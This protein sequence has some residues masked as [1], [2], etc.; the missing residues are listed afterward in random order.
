M[1][2]SQKGFVIP[3]I[4]VIVA[5]LV[6]GGGVYFYNIKNKSQKTT[7]NKP[8]VVLAKASVTPANEVGGGGINIPTVNDFT[9]TS[10]SNG[11]TWDKGD[12]TKTINW[13]YPDALKGHSI[14]LSIDLFNLDL[15]A[16]G[17]SSGDPDVDLNIGNWLI[18]VPN[19]ENGEIAWNL[20]GPVPETAFY[21]YSGNSKIVISVLDYS[22]Q[23]EY[24]SASDSFVVSTNAVSSNSVVPINIGSP[25]ANAQYKIGDSLNIEWGGSTNS[26]DI[27]QISLVG[28][29]DQNGQVIQS[30]GAI[31]PVGGPTC[32]SSAFTWKISSPYIHSGYNYNLIIKDPFNSY[33]R[34]ITI[35]Q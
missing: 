5:L 17:K 15:I 3:L 10:P 14:H 22:D 21:G 9:I 34:T 30:L 1:K 2:N 4:I 8:A 31:I 19:S 6:I 29:L 23:K 11:Q 13:T 32:S 27:C 12:S 16:K 25:T 24:Q 18:T 20:L 7:I 26:S 33:A 28:P 35:T